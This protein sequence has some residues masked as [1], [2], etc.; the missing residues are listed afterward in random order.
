[1]TP[2]RSLQEVIFAVH[3]VEPL[4]VRTAD[5][6]DWISVFGGSEATYQEMVPLPTAVVPIPG[7]SPQ[8]ASVTLLGDAFSP[9]IRVSGPDGH[10]I[11]ALQSD[12]VAFGWQRGVEVGIDASYPGYEALKSSWRT[13]VDRFSAWAYDRFSQRVRPRLVELGYYNAYPIVTGGRS[14]RLSEICKLIRPGIRPVNGMQLSWVET[15]DSGR[16]VVQANAGNGTAPPGLPVFGVNYFGFINIRP[17]GSTEGAD[18]V[19]DEVDTLHDH[20]STMHRATME[21]DA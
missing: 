13:Q 18:A 17:H 19:L 12:R 2:T 16:G 7:Q 3:F 10:S 8:L 6:A 21:E 14:K 11:S 9:R 15:V 20:I 4:P 1:M 5:L